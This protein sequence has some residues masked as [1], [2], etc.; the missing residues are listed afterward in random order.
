MRELDKLEE[1]LR[2]HGYT[3]KRIDDESY[4]LCNRH[5]VIVNKGTPDQ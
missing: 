2:N 4:P 3:Y 5:Q 1:Y